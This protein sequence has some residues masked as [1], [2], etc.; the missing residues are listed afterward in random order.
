MALLSCYTE[1][2]LNPKVAFTGEVDLYAEVFPVGGVALKI[3]AA[4]DLGLEK[5]YISKD[6]YDELNEAGELD[7]FNIEIK[8]VENASQIIDEVFEN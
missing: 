6:N 5:I 3:A 8:P 2:Q 4:Q 7:K 1:K